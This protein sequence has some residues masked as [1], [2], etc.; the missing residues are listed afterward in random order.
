MLKKMM[1]P[2]YR[3]FEQIKGNMICRAAGIRVQDLN[4]KGACLHH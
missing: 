1:E 2:Y 4:L 3:Q